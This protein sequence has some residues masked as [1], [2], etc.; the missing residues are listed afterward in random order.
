MKEAQTLSTEKPWPLIGRDTLALMYE[1]YASEKIVK[2]ERKKIK[3]NR[4]RVYASN[5][6]WTRDFF[7][8]IFIDGI[9][10]H[11]GQSVRGRQ[12]VLEHFF[13]RDNHCDP[14]LRDAIEER[15]LTEF[16]HE[17]LDR[18]YQCQLLLEAEDPFQA[19][20]AYSEHK[21]GSDISFDPLTD[22]DIGAKRCATMTC[23]FQTFFERPIASFPAIKNGQKVTLKTRKDLKD[24]F[25][26]Q[27]KTITGHIP[28]RLSTDC[29]VPVQLPEGRQLS[30][31]FSDPN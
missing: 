20:K 3:R 2:A 30:I 31:P 29:C 7:K 1:K 28:G 5:L 10:I 17:E 21:V 22:R 19:I 14:A 23:F 11:R 12:E 27:M 18:I 16:I 24:E 9:G 15:R 26:Q 6:R 4:N 8:A 25:G 13:Q